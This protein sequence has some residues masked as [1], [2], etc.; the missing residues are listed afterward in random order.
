[1]LYTTN[2]LIIKEF[3]KYLIDSLIFPQQEILNDRSTKR[4]L[5]ISNSYNEDF[6]KKNIT[7]EDF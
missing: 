7:L 2:Y 4:K 5:N 1:M 3:A 6:I